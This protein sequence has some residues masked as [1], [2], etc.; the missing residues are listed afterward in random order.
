MK[1]FINDIK[2]YY[3]YTFYSAKAELKSEVADSYLG[4]IWWFLEPLCFMFVYAFV[5]MV[6]FKSKE[7]YML[8]FV[9]IGNILWTFF[10]KTI[11]AGVKIVSSNKN[12]VAKVYIP[13]YMLVL[14]KIMVNLFKLLVS[15]GIVALIMLAYRVPLTFNIISLIPIIIT[16]VLATFG[17]S[18]ILAHFGV[19]VDDLSNIITILL[20][21]VFY[22]SGIFFSVSKRIPAPYGNWL[23]KINPVAFIIEESRNVLIYGSGANY[24]Y[25]GIWVLISIIL[26]VIGIK[27]IYKYEN[28]YVKVM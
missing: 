20:K 6:V 27:L 22:L 17:M 13:K 3:K 7:E 4:W 10:N 2:K 15:F 23:A 28:S 5:V 1:R 14:V 24:I 18:T 21:I 9:F 26:C 8:A 19:F 11:T 25:M 12:I 16:F